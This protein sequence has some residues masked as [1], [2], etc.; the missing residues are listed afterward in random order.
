M[1]AMTEELNLSFISFSFK[2]KKPHVAHGY[3]TAQCNFKPTNKPNKFKSL[4]TSQEVENS[5]YIGL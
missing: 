4:S 2:F 1:A 3:S 5:R